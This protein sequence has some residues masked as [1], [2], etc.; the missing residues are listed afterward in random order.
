MTLEKI[1]CQCQSKS[2][3]EEEGEVEVQVQ[4]QE[5]VRTMG[6]QLIEALDDKEF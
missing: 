6:E 5:V 2:S 4:V 3:L 1:R